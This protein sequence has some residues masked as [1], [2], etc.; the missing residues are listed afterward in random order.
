MRIASASAWCRLGLG[1]GLGFRWA[2]SV[3]DTH[4][5]YKAYTKAKGSGDLITGGPCTMLKK[6]MRPI[7]VELGSTGDSRHSCS[8]VEVGVIVLSGIG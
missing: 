3:F 7:A 1:L 4:N 8:S 2:S 6:V 5:A